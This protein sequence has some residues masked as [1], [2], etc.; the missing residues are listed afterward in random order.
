MALFTTGMISR[1]AFNI[2]DRTENFYMIGSM[3]LLNALGLGLA[4]QSP[5]RT[6]WVIEGDG[7]TLMSLG[8]LPLIASCRPRNLVHVVLDN[9][10]YESTGGQPTI[11]ATVDLAALAQAAGYTRVRHV[12]HGGSLQEALL[13]AVA[14]KMLTFILAKVTGRAPEG[15]GRVALTPEQIKQRFSRVLTQA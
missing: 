7:S 2:R 14:E 4:L 6:T 13:E 10:A 9:E 1:E 11:S 15:L 5:S 3:G 12:R 8:T